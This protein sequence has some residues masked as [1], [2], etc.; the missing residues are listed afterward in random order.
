MKWLKN[1]EKLVT[2]FFKMDYVPFSAKKV[3]L[4]ARGIVYFY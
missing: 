4:S 1:S 3:P 2:E